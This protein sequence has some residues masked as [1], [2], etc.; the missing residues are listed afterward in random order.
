VKRLLSTLLLTLAASAGAQELTLDD[1]IAMA[2]AKNPDL[3]VERESLH[4]ADAGILRAEAAYEPSLRGEA[5]LRERTDPANSILSG[6]PRGELAPTVRTLQTSASLVQLL[7]TGG[8]IAVSTG[9]Q[10]DNTNSILTLLTPS[11]TTL[12][13]AEVRQPLFQNRRIDPARRAIR[14]ARVDRTRALSSLRRTAAE[15]TAAV[16]RTYWTLVAATREMGIRETSLRTAEKQREDTRVRIEAGTQAE[17]D[18]A[19]T[20]A[21]VERRHGDIPTVRE[22]RARAENALRNLIGTW[23]GELNVASGVALLASDAQATN[24]R[25]LT[26]EA[27]V[28]TAWR[29]RPE[30]EELQS[31]VARQD[32]EL[33][34][35]L[36]RVRPQVDL[37]ANYTGRGL[38]GTRNEDAIQPF[39][40]IVVGD[41]ING[42]LGRSLRSIDEFPDASLGISFVIPIGNTAAKQDVTIARAVRRQAEASIDGA[43]QRVAME[44]RNAIA[45]VDSAKQRIAAAKAVREAAEV[46]LQGERDR[47]EAGTTNLFFIITRENELAAAQL[48][49]TIA[50]A[51]ARK[52]ETELARAMGTL[53]DERSIEVGENQ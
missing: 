17:A 36:D 6:A 51:D 46:Q 45:A 44:V 34:A 39:G 4:I 10:R 35:A 13:G 30:L 53:L 26:P 11:W 19:S 22:N 27:A 21:E 32:V 40:P 8:T 23:D 18:L 24:R 49:E 50:F 33:E 20:N 38:A 29:N 41:E 48:A 9:V 31:R 16:E 2:L 42:G 37:V 3:I 15:T 43:R 1:A 5:R 12:L 14:I 28:S 52:A 47:Y 7:P 25:S